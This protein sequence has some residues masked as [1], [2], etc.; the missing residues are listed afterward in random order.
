M[1]FLSAQA[2]VAYMFLVVTIFMS[3]TLLAHP[4]PQYRVCNENNAE[5]VVVEIG[6]MFEPGYDQLGLCQVGSSFV[7]SIDSMIYLWN[8]GMPHSLQHYTSFSSYECASPKTVYSL[9]GAE[10]QLCLFDDGS[11]IDFKTLKTGKNSPENSALNNFL[12]L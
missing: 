1:K 7:G 9:E 2:I 3:R 11:V 8:G 6:V 12:K 5:F 10:I 4:N